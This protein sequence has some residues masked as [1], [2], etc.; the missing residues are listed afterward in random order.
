MMPSPAIPPDAP[1]CTSI[2]LTDEVRPP[3]TPYHGGWYYGRIKFADQYPY[4][5]PGILMT[6]P[7]GRFQTDTRICLSMSDFHPETWNPMWSVAT[8]LTGL[9]SFM[10]GTDMTTG[11]VETSEEEKKRLARASMAWNMRHPTFAKY[12]PGAQE[13]ARRR[14]LGEVVDVARIR[15][16]G[17]D[18]DDDGQDDRSKVADGGKGA[19]G[20]EQEA[21]EAGKEKRNDGHAEVEG[22]AQSLS[23]SPD[24]AAQGQEGLEE[25]RCTPTSA[26]FAEGEAVVMSGLSAKNSHFNGIR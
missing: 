17:E 19:S 15:V 25:E 5:P 8:V 16:L 26:D 3:D 11:A 10:T 13:Y 21:E 9:L 14:A 23:S 22:H 6:T 4:S 24:K 12:F 7:S 20:A 2:T 18:D 1:F